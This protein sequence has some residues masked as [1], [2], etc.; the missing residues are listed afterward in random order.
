[1]EIEENSEIIAVDN[2]EPAPSNKNRIT[3][4]YMTKYE[5]ARI[6][7]ARSLQLRYI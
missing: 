6:L 7:G 5:K 3:T 1:M 2:D 4:R